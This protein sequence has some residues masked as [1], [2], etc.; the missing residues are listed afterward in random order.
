M[1]GPT[2]GN[3]AAIEDHLARREA[4]ECILCGA[5]L[6]EEHERDEGICDDCGE[7]EA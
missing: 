5:P 3:L 4:T 2:D 6:D 7:D 1:R